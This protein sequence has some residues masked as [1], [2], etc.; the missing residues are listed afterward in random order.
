MAWSE[1]HGNYPGKCVVCTHRHCRP[2]LEER[3]IRLLHCDEGLDTP[4]IDM[5]TQHGLERQRLKWDVSRSQVETIQGHPGQPISRRRHP[6]TTKDSTSE[7]C[8]WTQQSCVHNC[9]METCELA[10][11]EATRRLWKRMSTEVARDLMRWM[12]PVGKTGNSRASVTSSKAVGGKVPKATF[13]A[14]GWE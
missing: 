3:C 7:V 12:L 9:R 14:K 11:C 5:H 2:K 13:H 1:V 8:C 4:W 10:W 6:T